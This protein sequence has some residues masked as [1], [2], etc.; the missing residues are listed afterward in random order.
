MF[1]NYR[2][3]NLNLRLI[4]ACIAITIIGVLVVGSARGG[5]NGYYQNRQIMGMIIGV[6][7]MTAVA[8]IDY[9]LLLQFAWGYYFLALGLLT[10]VLLWGDSSLG[11]QRWLVI[12]GF[13]FQPSELAKI[14]L[15]LFFS[16][17]LMRNEEK[18]NQPK[19]LLLTVFLMG[20]PLLLIEREP[21]LST[22]IVT[23]LILATMLFVAGLTYKVVAPVLGI[24]IPLLIIFLV[25]ESRGQSL[26]RGYQD[27]R[28]LAWLRPDD[29]PGD[30]FQQQ[31]SIM[32]VGS[33]RIFGKGL[34][35]ESA[36]SVKNGN[37][38]PEPHTDFIFA[39][40]SEEMGFIGA[41]VIIALLL[42]IA[43][44]CIRVSKKAKDTAGKLI[45]I[46]MASYISIQSFVN[47]C[48]VTGLMPNTGLTLPF[49]SYGL[50]SLV[51]TY[52]GIGLVLNV[53]LQAKK[54]YIDEKAPLR[55]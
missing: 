36:Q 53:G 47:I 1:R 41:F 16:F 17:F 15:I 42:V 46:G 55:W 34:F 10:A 21:D 54:N 24:S 6:I 44:E 45:C 2:L 51:T 29:Y 31:N 11:A 19:T 7:V 9:S 3:K 35:N 4:I 28:I 23:F 33:G 22:T 20:V 48:V 8:V 39:V 38:I 13:R 25:M 14:L 26:L 50:T 5:A 52:I 18:I 27:K 40:A 37:Y 32:A 30:S 49:V 43:I 12:H